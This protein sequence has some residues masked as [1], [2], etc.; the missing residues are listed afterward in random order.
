MKY[1]PVFKKAAKENVGSVVNERVVNKLTVCPPS[2]ALIGRYLQGLATEYGID[3]QPCEVGLPRDPREV[4][5]SPEGFSV[6]MAPGSGLAGVYTSSAPAVSP[7]TAREETAI[8]QKIEDLTVQTQS[9]QDELA[10]RGTGG[11]LSSSSMPTTES[12]PVVAVSA[13]SITAGAEGRKDGISK[14]SPTVPIS[15][16]TDPVVSVSDGQNLGNLDASLPFSFD[17]LEARF[18]ALRK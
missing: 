16:V 10:L 9:L 5:A 14:T 13:V 18:T 6:P 11:G 17:E 4:L 12:F 15:T 7:L 3:W 1:G 8:R 2:V